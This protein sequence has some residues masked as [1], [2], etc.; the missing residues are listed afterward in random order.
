MSAEQDLAFSELTAPTT[1]RRVTRASLGV[2]KKLVS[3]VLGL[4]VILAVWYLAVTWTH[5]P[6]YIFPK[7]T[8]VVNSTLNQPGLLWTAVLVTLKTAAAGLGLAIAIGV[9]IGVVL[10][11][12]R[13]LQRSAFP[14]AVVLQTTPVVAIAPIVVIVLGPNLGSIVMIVFLISFFPMLSGTLV[15][16]NSVDPDLRGVF[17]LYRAPRFKTLLKLR[18]P[19]AIPYIVSGLKVASGL[20]IIGAIVGEYVAGVGGAQGGLGY[21]LVIEAQQLNTAFLIATALAGSLMGLL[22]YGV[23]AAIS[24]LLTAWQDPGAEREVRGGLGTPAGG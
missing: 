6:S 17:Q 16:L 7:P 19:N 18:L 1:T 8:A 5:T 11:L 9:A 2:G 14:Y 4:V 12:S 23:V 10:G 13:P 24:R 20:S 22:F 15:G 21:L 3:P